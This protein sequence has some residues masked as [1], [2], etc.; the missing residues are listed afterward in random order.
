MTTLATKH[1][2]KEL[3]AALDKAVLGLLQ[4]KCSSFLTAIY[5]AHQVVFENCKTAYTTG[6][7]LALDPDWFMGLTDR[8]KVS[9]LAH[10]MWHVAYMHTDPAVWHSRDR[11]TLNQAMDHV[12]NLMLI[13][14]GYHFDMP[15]C[16]DARFKDMTTDQ[17]YNVLM[18]EKQNAPPQSCAGTGQGSG[19]G[20]G[21]GPSGP[22][23]SPDDDL[24]FGEDVQPGTAQEASDALNTVLRAVTLARMN[25]QA[26]DLPG[27]FL[28][29]IDELLSPTLP[30]EVLLRRW[31][32]QISRE[33]YTWQRPNRRYTPHGMYLPTRAGEEGLDHLMFAMDSSGSMTDAQLQ[34]LNTEVFDVK[35]RFNPREMTLVNFDTSIRNEWYIDEDNNFTT[36]DFKGRG[37]TDLQD[38][39]RRT[40]ELKPTALVVLSDMYCDIPERPGQTP[41]LWVCF[42]NP[43]WVPPYGTVI[44]LDTSK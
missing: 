34:V 10:E 36:L 3:Q 25:N 26:G 14:H 13:D 37:G 38:V 35:A 30:W 8:S 43:S 15:G 21:G 5:C 18:N 24:P 7:K 32:N 33:G 12:I 1:T 16:Y 11:R 9:L 23:G 44:H 41:V 28:S 40:K 27:E 17:V 31:F 19:S 39:W 4:G 22:P 20:P 42:D 2:E 6:N 29:K